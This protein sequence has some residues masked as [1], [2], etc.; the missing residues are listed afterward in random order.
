[1]RPL[2]NEENKSSSDI[3]EVVCWSLPKHVLINPNTHRPSDTQLELDLMQILLID[4]K[5]K[6][7]VE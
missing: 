4:L 3:C 2:A 5:L 7:S 1:M 6:A